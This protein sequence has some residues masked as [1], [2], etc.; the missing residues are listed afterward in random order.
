MDPDSDLD[1]AILVIDLQDANTKLIVKK[2]VFCLYLFEG[3]RTSL[4]E[5][6]KSKRNN[7]NSR[8]QGFSYYFFMIE[9]SGSIPATIGSGSVRLKNMWIRW[10][11]IQI[12]KTAVLNQL[13]RCIT[14]LLLIRIPVFLSSRPSSGPITRS[15]PLPR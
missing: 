11:R 6:K 8:N 5:D 7:Q 9:G 4:F 10:I 12:G 2:R 3:T 14:A 13:R 15:T 1:P